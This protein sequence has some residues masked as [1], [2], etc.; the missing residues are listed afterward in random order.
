MTV[1]R[2]IGPGVFSVGVIDWDRRLFDELIPLPDGTSYNAYI[3]RGDEKNAL[4]DSADPPFAEALLENL[5]ELGID[6]LDYVVAH[7]AEQDHSGSIPAVLERF[8]G[9]KVVCTPR[10]R[11]LLSILLDIP[12][13]RFMTVEERS[14]LSLGGKTLEFLYTPWVHWP[15]TM[16]T[17]LREEKILFSCDF[18]G[19]HYATSD[20][21]ADPKIIYEPAKRYYAEIMMPFRAI[22]R[23]NLEVVDS[24]E[25][26]MIAPSHGPLHD[27][28]SFILEAYRDWSSEE[29]KNEVVIPF[30][31]MHGSTRLMVDHLTDGLIARGIGVRRFDIAV[32]DVG[33]IAEAL[34]DAATLVLGTSTV[35]GGPHPNAA[36][37][38]FLANALRPKTRFA[39][40]IGS[41]GWG[42]K[43]VKAIQEAIPLLKVEVMEP[44]LAK[45]LPT[46]QDY[47]ALDRLA[48][49]ILKRHQELGIA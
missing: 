16:V 9:A 48:D 19:S 1:N 11:E 40:I 33:K 2:E 25:I 28:P 39:S 41:Y 36:H 22:I 46:A 18:F 42:G 20:L 10:C 32:S 14:T 30:V 21:F 6:R 13:E 8:P 43:T 23:K 5:T 15:E 26:K 24:L 37:V 49:E 27:D 29:V 31:S 44:V 12:E 47:K 17:Y 4:I 35:L 45:G 7:H 3:V 34:V 38:A